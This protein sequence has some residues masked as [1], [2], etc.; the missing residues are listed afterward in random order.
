MSAGA[1]HTTESRYEPQIKF[2]QG[3]LACDFE[4]SPQF[5]STDRCQC[6]SVK[7]FSLNNLFKICCV[8]GSPLILSHTYTFIK[9][10]ICEHSFSETISGYKSESLAAT[11]SLSL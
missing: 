8:L 5:V 1:T 2:T 9:F 3:G 6:T 11:L 7:I 4:S 10:R